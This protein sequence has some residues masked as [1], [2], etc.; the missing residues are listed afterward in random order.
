MRLFLIGAT[1]RIGKEIVELGLS[2]GHEVTAF[3]RSP[4]KLNGLAGS[5]TVVRGNPLDANALAAAL[6]GH[7]AVLSSLGLPPREALRPST[8]MAT[9]AQSTIQAMKSSGVTRLAIVSAA[10]LFPETGLLFAFFRWFLRHHARDLAAMEHLIQMSGLEWTIARPPRLTG[11]PDGTFR[12]L[13][14]AMPPNG[15]TMPIRSV[16]RFMLDA[17]EHHQ[18]PRE[19]VGVAR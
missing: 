6:P 19:I 1:G 3:V 4:D 14:N 5:L 8:F 17:V 16:A 11:S 10:V 18:Y 15:L 9:T 13:P 12:A 2:R 7:H